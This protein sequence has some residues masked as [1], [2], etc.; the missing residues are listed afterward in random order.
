[1]RILVGTLMQQGQVYGNFHQSMIEVFQNAERHK[2]AI[3]NQIARQIPNFD[4][5]NQEHQA[6]FNAT[7]NA[8]TIEVGQYTLGG[9]SLLGRGRNHMA[10]VALT[11]G[12][13]KLFFIDA[14]EG[15]T[16]EQFRAIAQSPHPVAAG[17][18]PLKAFPIPNSYETV[19]NYLPFLEDEAFFDDSTRTLK[20]TKRLARAKKS[21]WIEVAYTGTGFL[22]V[23]VSVFAKLAE[24]SAEY[25]YPNPQTGIPQVHWSFFDGGPMY[26][27]YLSEDW[28]FCEK[29]REAGF[30]IMVNTDVQVTHA[31]PHTFRAG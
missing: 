4:L 24:K 13:D 29:A 30:K 1:M 8:H 10:Q 20:A 28:T 12:W 18:V 26:G 21:N 3:A 23:D 27:Q 31:G 6:T 11:Q 5:K 15:F 2:Q 17:L 7:M 22:C 14:D 19:L 9:E 16:W 25:T